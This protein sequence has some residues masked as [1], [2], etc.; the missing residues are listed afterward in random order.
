MPKTE[1]L[2]CTIRDGSYVIDFQFSK[3]NVA[4][5]V[6]GLS[7]AGISKIEVGHG[8]G[9]D[10]ER[11]QYN[12]A[13][14][15]E[16]EYIKTA[17]LFKDKSKIGHFFIPGIGRLE[18][19]K[20]SINW[21]L[22]F[23]RIGVNISEIEKARE[24]VKMAKD[25]GL[26][27]SINLMKSY[28]LNIKEFREKVMIADSFESDI[29]CVVDSAG[30][31]FQEDIREYIRS[32]KD[33]IGASLGFHG[34]NNLMLAIANSIT[35]IEEGVRYIDC[36]LLG[37]GR[38]GGN[39]QTEILATILA[40]KKINTEL[41]IYKLMDL[42]EK[43]IRPLMKETFGIPFLDVTAGIA[44][45]HSSFLNKFVQIAEKHQI[46]LRDLII[47]VS[48][49]DKISPSDELIN[50]IA[51]EIVLEK[52]KSKGIKYPNKIFFNS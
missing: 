40:K 19:I 52:S 6:K 38:S 45:F 4:Y 47:R 39:A 35:A 20:E 23:I 42:G 37:M 8:V 10:A 7:E 26:E 25:C 31:M 49:I 15:T 48:A 12:P 46:D 27:T 16:E 2:D 32:I 11:S 3:K 44:Q 21:G 29:I 17:N 36:S 18:K 28:A 34:H 41:D 33:K 5:L 50:S 13:T 14:H 9:F 24:S 51:Q 22:D 1:I 30:G 43:Y